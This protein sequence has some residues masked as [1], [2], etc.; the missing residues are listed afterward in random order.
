MIPMARPARSWPPLR[1]ALALSGEA[2]T[3]PSGAE[4]DD[5]LHQGPYDGASARPSCARLTT[6]PPLTEIS[7][8]P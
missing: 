4:P 8:R 3:E 6:V 7:S 2:L 5:G 1:A